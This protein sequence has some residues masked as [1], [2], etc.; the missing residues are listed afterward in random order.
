[1]RCLSNVRWL[2]EHGF[3]VQLRLLVRHL[4]RYSAVNR[5]RHRSPR[6]RAGRE[7]VAT[8]TGPVGRPSRPRLR[9]G[10]T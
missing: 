2:V 5:P 7:R 9:T 10:W 4:D 8:G 3:G 6:I 1:L